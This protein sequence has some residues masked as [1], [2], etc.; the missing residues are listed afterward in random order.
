[1]IKRLLAYLRRDAPRLLSDLIVVIVGISLSLYLS[2]VAKGWSDRAEE[3]RVLRSL[4]GELGVDLHELE[5]RI[6]MI[7]QTLELV[8][9]GADPA[10]SG[11][12]DTAARDR[13]MDA[14]LGYVT[15][16]QTRVTW[17]ELS[18]SGAADLIRDKELMREI[19][20]HYQRLSALAREW[21][22]INRDFVLDRVFA[23][24]DE[25]GPAFPPEADSAFA[26]GYHRAFDELRED[27]VFLNLMRTAAMFKSGQR[28]VYR[29]V[30]QNT[31]ALIEKIDGASPAP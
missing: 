31:R 21:D 18:Q 22:T 19:I 8:R 7:E 2:D 12:L 3:Q 26:A 11:D 29:I 13:T 6:E 10:T 5:Q 27:R 4:R 20:A 28:D 9:R 1:M 30:A 15:F 17:S 25:H 24:V 23:Y 16:D 14:M